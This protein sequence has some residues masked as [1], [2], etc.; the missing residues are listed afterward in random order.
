MTAA[1]GR[2]SAAI[3]T[4]LDADPLANFGYSFETIES[5]GDWDLELE[6]D[7]PRDNPNRLHVDLVGVR[8]MMTLASTVAADGTKNIR[9]AC[10]FQIIVRRRLAAKDRVESSG[11]IS[12]P[13]VQGL[14]ECV[15]KIAM[16]F[17]G[18]ELSTLADA[19]WTSEDGDGIESIR[20]PAT[21]R[22]N[23]QFTGIGRVSYEL[24]E[25]D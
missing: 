10:T 25:R 15:E 7:G 24:V 8:D 2:I 11:R 12:F 6:D 19:N 16:Y 9:H 21:L 1:L 3:A 20:Y 14:T 18:R 4:D 5:G 23:S 13:V 17:V 22:E